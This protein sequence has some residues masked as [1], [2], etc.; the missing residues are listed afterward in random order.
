[1]AVAARAPT[2]KVKAQIAA[3]A[4]EPVREVERAPAR[5]PRITGYVDREGNPLTRK[6]PSYRNEFDFKPGEVPE[7]WVYQ[8]IR[9]TVHGDPEYS[10]LFDMQE[11]GWR[12][13]PH[14]RHA[15]RFAPYFLEGT[16]KTKAAN[17]CIYRRGNLLVERPVGLNEEAFNEQQREANSQVSTQFGSLNVPLPDNVRAMGIEPRRG[18]ARQHTNDVGQVRADYMPKHDLAIDQ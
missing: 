10:E 14:S 18:V 3:E 9:H 13:V 11:N 16:D 6:N 7:G 1:M 8:W 2:R 17:A 15:G 12:P 4:Q 5:E